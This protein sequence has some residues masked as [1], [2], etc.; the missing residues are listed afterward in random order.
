MKFLRKFKPTAGDSNKRLSKNFSKWDINDVKRNPLGCIT[1][2]EL[3]R[4]DLQKLDVQID[5]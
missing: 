4:G 2:I 3:L 5:N 1:D